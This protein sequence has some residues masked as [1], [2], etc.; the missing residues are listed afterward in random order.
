MI[1]R[2]LI[3]ILSFLSLY[4]CS[5]G[6]KTN[7]GFKIFLAGNLLEQ[8]SGGAYISAF[9]RTTSKSD[10]YKLDSSGSAIIPYGTYDLQ[11]VA[12]EGPS[13][14]MGTI[15]CSSLSNTKLSTE[16]LTITMDLSSN[17]CAQTKYLT[18]ILTIKNGVSARWGFDLYDASHWGP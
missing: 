12:F 18:T 9:E 10:I 4:S 8:S 7:A 2:S 15:L 3:F 16:E 17:E 6:P 1:M 11:A 14:R 5:Q 13:D